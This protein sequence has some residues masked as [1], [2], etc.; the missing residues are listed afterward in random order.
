[1]NLEHQVKV[2]NHYLNPHHDTAISG[3][4]CE[5][6]HVFINENPENN[7]N[8]NNTTQNMVIQSQT[9]KPECDEDLRFLSN[10]PAKQSWLLRL[11]ESKLFDMTIAI[12]Y[13]YNSKESG[14]SV[15]LIL[16]FHNLFLHF[17]CFIISWQQTFHTFT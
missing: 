3:D 4:D 8:S 9:N 11:F 6:N 1:M 2:M 10:K 13:L 12:T 15:I 5:N 14:L 7:S 16:T 17:R